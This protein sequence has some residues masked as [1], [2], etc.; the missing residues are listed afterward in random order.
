MFMDR[1]NH[2]SF[3]I[4]ASFTTKRRKVVFCLDTHSTGLI[5]LV[6]KCIASLN[7]AKLKKTLFISPAAFNR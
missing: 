6:H 1:I 3:L 7:E 4:Y 2:Y 5:K